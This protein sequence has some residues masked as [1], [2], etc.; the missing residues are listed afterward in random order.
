MQLAAPPLPL[1]SEPWPMRSRPL[2]LTT[3]PLQRLPV[4]VHLYSTAHVYYA[5]FVFGVSGRA[6]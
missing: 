5:C 4:R 3:S 2:A 1:A 6:R